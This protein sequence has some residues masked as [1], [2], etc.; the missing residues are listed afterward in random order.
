MCSLTFGDDASAE[1]NMYQLL[2]EPINDSESECLGPL[3]NNGEVEL[4]NDVS[5]LQDLVTGVF[6]CLRVL[7]S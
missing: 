4:K 6:A 1:L 3:M 5:A 7:C 2:N